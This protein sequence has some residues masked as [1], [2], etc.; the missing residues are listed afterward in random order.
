M[1]A[2]VTSSAEIWRLRRSGPYQ[3]VVVPV[4]DD[5]ALREL[6]HAVALVADGAALVIVDVA[7]AGVAGHEV[8]DWVTAVVE[9]QEF[10][11][12]ALLREKLRDSRGDVG[13]AVGRG[14]DRGNTHCLIV[15]RCDRRDLTENA[16]SDF[17]VLLRNLG[18][19][20]R[21]S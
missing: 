20:F 17:H 6:A 3:I 4:N 16:Q 21:S 18:S 7:N 13:S 2:P 1:S 8:G 15:Q 11:I 10:G 5:L 12:V 19:S 14:H 9:D